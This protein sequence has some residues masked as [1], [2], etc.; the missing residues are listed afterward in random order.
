MAAPTTWTRKDLIGTEDLSLEEVNLLFEEADRMQAALDRPGGRVE[1]S[2]LE[3]RTVVNLFLEPSTR[4]RVA[5]EVAAQKLGAHVI[6]ISGEASSLT[7][8]ESLR[9]TAQNIQ[10]LQA[11][12]LI[13]RHSAPGSPGYLAKLLHIPL[14]NAGDGAHEHPTQALLD[15]YTL[16]RHW[17]DF[18]GK[19]VTILGDIL[20]SRVARSNIWLLTKLGAEVTLAGPSTLVPRS[21]TALAPGVHVTHN[22]REALAEADAVMLLRI[23]HERQSS[24]HFPSLGE[25]RGL[26]GL[27]KFRAGWLKPGALIMHPGPINRGVEIDNDLADAP[28]SVILQQVQSGVVTRMAALQ[29]CLA[30]ALRQAS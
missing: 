12:L 11:D 28:V 26:F 24:T 7:K 6:T 18:K 17:G 3:G 9:D 13:M 30:A 21:F 5:F 27:N 14:I 29:L 23:Q 4:T 25:Y 2:A 1:G 20:F 22:L 8:G 15:A 16:R 19:R 10:S